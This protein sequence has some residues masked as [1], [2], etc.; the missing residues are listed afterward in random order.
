M[1]KHNTMSIL[2][3]NGEESS[4]ENNYLVHNK[5]IYYMVFYG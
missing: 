3:F 4:I 1:V 2:N 5:N